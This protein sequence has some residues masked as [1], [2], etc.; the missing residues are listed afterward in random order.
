MAG[1]RAKAGRKFIDGRL[2][3]YT[4]NIVINKNDYI[5]IFSSFLGAPLLCKVVCATGRPSLIC[6]LTSRSR[7][8]QQQIEQMEQD[9]ESR[10]AEISR[11]TSLR[12][13]EIYHKA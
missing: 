1:A 5:I 7:N 12:V 6:M 4:K 10:R 11:L 8:G 9:R 13:L 2:Y 3:K